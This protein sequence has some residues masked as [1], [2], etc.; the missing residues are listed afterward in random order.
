MESKD[1]QAEIHPLKSEEGNA[2]GKGE[3]N[4]A[5]KVGVLRTRGRLSSWRTAA[6]F[7]SLFLCLTVV[8]AFSFI[9]PCPVR[10][11]SQKTWNRTFDNTVA[12]QFLATRDV[13]RDSVQ[14]VL[15]A[16]QASSGGDNSSGGL[17]SSCADEGFA[18]P[19]AFLTALSGTD[20]R[21]LWQK[22]VAEEPLVVDCSV[23]S[24]RSPGCLVVGKPGFVT[25]LDLNTGKNLWKQSA[26]FG[27]NA[28]VLKPLLEVPDVDGDGAPD[29]LVLTATG[30]EIKS[31]FFSGKHGT[32]LGSQGSLSLP[33]WI[34]HLLQ[35]TKKGAHYVLFCTANA[36]YGYSVKEL[37]HTAI[38]LESHRDLS[39]TE[40]PHWEVAI[41]SLSHT[42]PLLSSS[43]IHYLKKMPGKSG[44]NIL[45]VRS[46][47]LELLDGQHLGSVWASNIPHTLSEPVFGSYDR[48]TVDIVI[49]SRVVPDRKKVMIVKGSSGDVDWETELL[50]G[51]GTPQAA[52]LATVNHRSVF[53][54]WGA[55]QEDANATKSE[56]T[57]QQHVLYL[58]HP[59]FTNV[60]LEMTSVQEPIVVFKAALLERSRH[61]CYLLLT[62]PQAGGVPGQVVVSKRKLKEDI[63]G[64][65]VIWLNRLAQD[66][67]QNVR[68][69]FLRMRYRSLG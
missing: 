61:A 65:R 14:D 44:T 33:G 28:T 21:T 48:D 5:E 32:L 45:V 23:E 26:D 67:E 38:G 50:W 1:L 3:A 12:Y 2:P 13:D 11:I 39:L 17:N 51:P 18:S 20:G 24:D 49:E 15:F 47:M 6:F 57:Q 34:G 4:C 64:S 63:G 42:L 46:A 37:Y 7:L 58:F 43:E 62:G 31:W 8:F 68:D 27:A 69:H 16:F 60:L 56:G 54:F 25:V 53:L 52:T 19:C 59:S 41:D 9:I 29:F 36:L 35:V 10:P 30:K 66:K 55:H 22:P 40:D